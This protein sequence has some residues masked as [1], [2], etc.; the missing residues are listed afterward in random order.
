VGCNG[1]GNSGPEAYYIFS[2][3]NAASVTVTLDGDGGYYPDLD[4]AIVGSTP[5]DCDPKGQCIAWGWGA[6]NDEQETFNAMGNVTYYFI[7]DSSL[8]AGN[9]F[10]LDVGCQ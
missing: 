5:N 6:Y 2:T 10:K 7:V 3:P 9:G 4:L 1:V 8:A